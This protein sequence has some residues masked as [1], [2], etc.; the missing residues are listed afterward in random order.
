MEPAHNGKETN[1][2]LYIPVGPDC[3][4]NRLYVERM[5]FQFLSGFSPPDF[6]SKPENEKEFTDRATFSDL[7]TD[8]QTMMGFFKK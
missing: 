7:S 4:I 6:E 5:R 1:T 2:V 3:P 8:G